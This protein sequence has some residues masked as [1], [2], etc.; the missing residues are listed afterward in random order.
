MLDL[1]GEDNEPPSLIE[2]LIGLLGWA[3]VGM[4][5]A[6]ASAVILIV[7]IRQAVWDLTH[8]PKKEQKKKEE[9]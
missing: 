9:A 7:M 8:R 6:A 1:L 3:V 4:V 2:N 5:L